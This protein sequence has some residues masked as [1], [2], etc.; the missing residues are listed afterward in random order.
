MGLARTVLA[1]AV[2]AIA[3][4]VP[5]GGSGALLTGSK[6]SAADLTVRLDVQGRA[7]VGAQISIRATVKNAGGRRASQVVLLLA[8]PAHTMF[9]SKSLGLSP[10]AGPKG[11]CD[12]SVI[13]PI[14]RCVIDAIA[15]MASVVLALTVTANASLSSRIVATAITTSPEPLYRNN[16]ANV[17]LTVS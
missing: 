7:S 8:P 9:V 2:I 10:G 5:S 12:G 11:A 3:I 13:D 14:V 1:C 6:T 16:F 17:P 4:I 15:P